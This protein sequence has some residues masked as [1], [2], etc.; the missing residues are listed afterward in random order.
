MQA[1]PT[2]DGTLFNFGKGLNSG[3]YPL[4]PLEQSV[5]TAVEKLL[6]EKPDDILA[7]ALGQLAMDLARN[8]QLGNIKGRAVANEAQQLASVLETIR[9]E[10]PA[11]DDGAQLP[12]GVKE[13]VAAL[14]QPPTGP[15]P[16]RDTA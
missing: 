11:A 16:V 13:F 4:S 7:P 3:G 1:E 12:E 10:K 2:S 14:S 5:A 8:V 15:T 6:A 9:G